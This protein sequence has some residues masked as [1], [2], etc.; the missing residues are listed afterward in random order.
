M[1]IS[2]NAT[3]LRP[4]I[5][6]STTRPTNP[7]TGFIIFETDTGYL[8][9]WDGAAWDYFLPKQDT[10]PGAWTSYTPTWTAATT[11]PAIGNGTLVGKYMQLNKVVTAEI[12]VIMGSTTTYGSGTFRFGLPVTAATPLWGYAHTGS[13]RL[14]DSSVS[15]IYVAA[16]GFFASSTTYVSGWAHAATSAMS[17]TSPFTWASG[18]EI[19]I[20][21]TYEAA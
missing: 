2:S 18:D 20:Q 17:S 11:N 16:I 4:G 14:Y 3:G 6:T 21:V 15:T 9:V 12:T 19:T 8:R 10:V 7:Y 5:C 1:A 13:A